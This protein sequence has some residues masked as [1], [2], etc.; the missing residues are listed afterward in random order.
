MTHASTRGANDHLKG[1][2]QYRALAEAVPVGIW[3]VGENGRTLFA[4]PLLLAFLGLAP[5]ELRDADIPLLLGLGRTG[6]PGMADRFE[7]ELMPARGHAR[8]VLVTS[9][10]WLM[11]SGDSQRSALVSVS[12]ISQLDELKRAND[13]VVRLNRA[14]AAHVEQ[15]KLARDEIVRRS[16]MAQLGQLTATVAHEIRNPLGAVQ[17]AAFIIER[18]TKGKDIGIEPQL[19]RIA[20]GLSRCDAI[21]AQLLDFSRSKELQCEKLVLD[22][23]LTSLVAEAAARLAAVVKVE[24][25][26]GTGG[27]RVPFD[28]QRLGRALLNLIANAS[29]AMVGKGDDRSKFTTP[30]PRIVIESRLTGRG[31]EISVADNGP[32]IAPEHLHKVL[33][34]LFTTKNFGTGLGLPAVEKILLEHGGGLEIASTPGQGARFTVWI[35]SSNA[36]QEA[37]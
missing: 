17:T 10:G 36:A 3:Q 31:A 19:Q 9:S 26:P 27:V 6:F 16:R 13:E 21:I 4:N 29:E 1:G 7:F 35:P 30:S 28:P 37:A 20:G 32:G 11:L 2:E 24:C 22:E 33:E 23:W 8:H 25:S 5:E 18:K 14:L 34:P 12:D 15:L